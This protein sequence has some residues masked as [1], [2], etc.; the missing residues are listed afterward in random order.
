MKENLFILYPAIFEKLRKY[1]PENTIGGK[2]KV[3]KIASSNFK[4]SIK[5]AYKG[6]V[7]YINIPQER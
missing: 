1:K 3:K 7:L 5:F 6:S 4:F 2:I